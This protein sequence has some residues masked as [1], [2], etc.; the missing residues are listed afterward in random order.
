MNF[1]RSMP[2]ITRVEH[3]SNKEVLRKTGSKKDHKET[4]VI[5]VTYYEGKK[6]WEL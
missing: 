4:F 2:R 1:S 3:V 5:A 6:A